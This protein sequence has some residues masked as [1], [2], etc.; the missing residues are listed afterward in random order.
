SRL[1]QSFRLKSLLVLG[2]VVLLMGGWGLVFPLSF[3]QNGV[4]QLGAPGDSDAVLGLFD[5]GQ[6][7][8]E[9]VREL[10]AKYIAWI[11]ALMCGLAVLWLA[12]VF[13]SSVFKFVFY[14]AMTLEPAGFDIRR[15]F[16][17]NAG[18]GF[19]LFV[20]TAC[21]E[22]VLIIALADLCV[23]PALEALKNGTGIA[24]ALDASDSFST[25]ALLF[26]SVNVL[27]YLCL[28]FIVPLMA[29]ERR[30]LPGAW[31]SFLGLALR[32][33][34]ELL[35]YSFLR[36]VSKIGGLVIAFLVFIP[37]FLGWLAGAGVGLV[38][39]VGLMK[40]FGTS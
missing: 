19:S 27:K 40:I 2:T 11:M 21:L 25:L 9:L 15:S 38:I 26:L 35:V 13:L 3:F 33:W 17:D 18:R 29:Q 36:L 32:Q 6:S 37:L 14:D 7:M 34:K 5:D 30:G 23:L 39:F 20:F 16:R 22:L 10:V 8:L 4:P 12:A 28:D 31:H 1:V 24:D